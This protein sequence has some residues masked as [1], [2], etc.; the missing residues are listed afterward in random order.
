[1]YFRNLLGGVDEKVVRGTGRGIRG[2][3]RGR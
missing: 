3:R 2:M 1:M